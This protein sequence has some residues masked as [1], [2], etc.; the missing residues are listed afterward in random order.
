M[1]KIVAIQD[2]FITLGQLLKLENI[3]SS[4]GMTKWYLSEYY[5]YVNE[6]EE[7]RRGKKLYDGDVIYFP[8]EELT[9]TIQSKIKSEKS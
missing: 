2:A 9:V 6:Q 4:G 1:K 3:I 7:Q 8:S 5:V